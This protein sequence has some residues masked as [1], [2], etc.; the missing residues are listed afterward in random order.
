VIKGAV[1]TDGIHWSSLGTVAS[2]SGRK[3]FFPA[4]SV[5]PTTGAVSLSFDALTSPPAQN[6]WQTGVQV[7]DNYYAQSGAGG[8]SFGA[9]IKVSTASSNPDAS[10]YNDLQEQFIG[11]YIGIVDGPD[12][13]YLAWT[14][15]RA[16]ASCA[17]VDDYRNEVYGGQ[18]VVPPNPDSACPSAFGN[19]DSEVGVV[20]MG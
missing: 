4:A 9:P 18:K 17:A 15:A 6:P 7:Y 5:S 20:S 14:D 8:T 19:T 2:V 11:D 10:S 13:A 1:S 3:T 12:T 16:A